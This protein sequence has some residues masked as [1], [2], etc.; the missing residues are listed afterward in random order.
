MD[1]LITPEPD[2]N[3]EEGDAE[4]LGVEEEEEEEDEEEEEVE[5]GG[6]VATADLLDV[7]EILL[8]C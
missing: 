5:E 1:C 3:V 8:L 4:V 7:V 2:E 6:G